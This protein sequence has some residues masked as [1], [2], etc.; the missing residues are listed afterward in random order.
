MAGSMSV[1][2][3]DVSE[4][5]K[6]SDGLKNAV[7][8][9][10]DIP[11]IRYVGRTMVS[12]EGAV[13]FDWSGTYFTVRFTGGYCAMRVSDT[14]KNYYN[15]FVDG[16]PQGVVTTFGQDS[17]VVLVSGFDR[18]EHELRVQKRTEGEQG[19]TTI[20][21]F[22][23]APRGQFIRSEKPTRH[24]EFIGNSLTC[25][26]GTEGLSKDDPFKPETE[27]CNLA[28]GCII[29]R[30]FGT[31]YTLIAHSG[32][33]VVR[34]WADPK[35]ASDCSMK[36]RMLRTFDEDAAVTWDFAKSP[37]R[38][39][40]VVINL[41]TN[42]FSTRPHPTYE[43]FAAAYGRI[44]AQI[45]TAYGDIPVLC[46]APRVD[47]PAYMYVKAF[48]DGCGD[49]KVAFTSLHTDYC[50][51]ESDLGSSYH[52]NYSGQRKMAMA[53]IPY[54]STLTGWHLEDKVVK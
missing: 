19:R 23:L 5:K 24:I 47:D 14:K 30:Y 50:N 15:V 46:V 53:L 25:G 1:R 49:E 16:E 21:G 9:R 26:F 37:Y 12:P 39:D 45:R 22:E 8:F 10:A 7:A 34:N 20:L 18:G 44:L 33:G 38:P 54:I 27:N 2:A 35:L 43:L 11:Q 4:E 17:L 40:I 51:G 41:G 36:D 6:Q 31:D 52:P 3:A 32:Q 48:C 28:F 13:S 42:D 29:A